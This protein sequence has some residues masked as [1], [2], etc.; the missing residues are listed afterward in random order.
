MSEPLSELAPLQMYSLNA[1]SVSVGRSQFSE[2]IVLEKQHGA[3]VLEL[4]LL[5]GPAKRESISVVEEENKD[6]GVEKKKPHIRF[7][8]K[9]AQRVLSISV[10]FIPC[11]GKV[12]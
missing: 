9:P 5:P 10:D 4:P 3:A 1:L 12:R 8:E 11:P 6:N 7:D 2:P